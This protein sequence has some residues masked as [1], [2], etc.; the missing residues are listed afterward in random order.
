MLKIEKILKKYI[1]YFFIIILVLIPFSK[2]QKEKNN[3]F[4]TIYPSQDK[5][6]SYIIHSF[7]P[8]SEH[9]T[10]DLSQENPNKIIKKEL[11][12]DYSNK[13]SS[14]FFYKKDY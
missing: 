4:F 6:T 8:Y 9:L 7:T 3:Y 10:I 14:T 13:Y 11:I 1:C 12:A 2:E 5:N